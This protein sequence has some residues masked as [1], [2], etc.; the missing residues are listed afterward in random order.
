MNLI[1]GAPFHIIFS[2]PFS[3]SHF[4]CQLCFLKYTVYHYLSSVCIMSFVAYHRTFRS[5]NLCPRNCYFKWRNKAKSIDA[6]SVLYGGLR[7]CKSWIYQLFHSSTSVIP[8]V[9]RCPIKKE[10]QKPF[11][12][13]KEMFCVHEK[14]NEGP[15]FQ[16]VH[17]RQR[18]LLICQPWVVQI[19][20][21]QNFFNLIETFPK[22][23]S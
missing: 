1:Y 4:L 22:W 16:D 15:V 6:R 5:K 8:I 3:S 14:Q 18:F 11:Y 21:K 7:C 20:I 17:W 19:V 12:S 23:P 2:W 9:N 13:L 10:H